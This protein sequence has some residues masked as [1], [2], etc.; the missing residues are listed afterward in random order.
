M[1][2]IKEGRDRKEKQSSQFTKKLELFKLNWG[3]HLMGV[4]MR[5]VQWESDEK[6]KGLRDNWI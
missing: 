5:D 4:M 1:L 2:G 3:K 6:P